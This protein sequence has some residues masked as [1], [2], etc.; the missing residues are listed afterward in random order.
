[1]TLEFESVSLRNFGPYRDVAVNLQTSPGSP[2]VVI[3]GENTLGKTRLFRALRWCL[4]GSPVSRQVSNPA[5]RDLESYF[6]RPARADG[7]TSMEVSIKFSADGKKFRLA[8]RAEFGSGVPRVSA[9]LRIDA[10]V[11]QQASIDAEIG[12]LLHPQIS[13]FFLFDGELLKD[14]YDRLNTD[15]ERDFIR[16]SID[17]VLG[18]PALQ[19]ALRDVN[20]LTTDSVMR[21]TKAIKNQQD[22]ESKKRELR[23]LKNEQESVEKD[24]RE[25][26]KALQEA[27][28]NLKRVKDEIAGIGEL[29]ADA[30]EQETLEAAAMGDREL[31]TQVREDMR[32][33]LA[34]GWR[35]IAAKRLQVVL[36]EVQQRNNSAQEHQLLVSS[37]RNRVEVLEK[38]IQGGVCQ[39]C[40][41][42]LP[43]PDE[44]TRAALSKAHEDL[45]NVEASGAEGPDLLLERR[46]TSLIDHSTIERF[47]DKN[48]QLTK[49]LSRQYER[50]RRLDGLKDRL[51]DHD[52][53]K[54]RT[55]ADQ[56]EKLDEIVDRFEQRLK[57]FKPRL[58]DIARDQQRIARAL[59][60]LPGARPEA[61]AESAFFE[62]VQ[63]LLGQTISRYQERT[64]REVES[65]ATEMFTRLVRDPQGY[66]GLRIARDYRVDLIGGSG[67]SID[68]SEGGKQLVALSLI[69]ALKHAAV[70]GGPVVLDSPLA[71]LDLKHR[72]NVLQTWVPSLG[73]QAI[74][75]VQSGELTEGQAHEIMA[76]MIGQEYRIFRPSNNPD[77][78]EIERTQ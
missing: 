20:E 54:I 38:Q 51:K 14:F 62:Y 55:L 74:L 9:D 39:T 58:D 72:A 11:I 27:Q 33:L 40:H 56:Q 24:Q 77:L 44:S 52:A 46:I 57:T 36:D 28:L 4:Y 2:I 76:T 73:N 21:Q 10:D 8:R 18:I 63:T 1:M 7:E 70:R 67:A 37:A 31:E 17:S 64:R 45:A 6:N 16:D 48:S 15:R 42:E 41:Q 35:A 49:I 23:K 68:T 32:V 65:I 19:L 12:K 25:I 43:P 3:H 69:G 22:A 26:Q 61:A 13:E 60:R 50:K 75:L 53:A 47:K 30:R 71:R 78:A 5:A 59:S 29:Q 34:K 66:Q